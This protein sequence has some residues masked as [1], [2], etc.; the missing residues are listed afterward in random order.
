M[1]I[2]ELVLYNFGAYQGRQ[3]FELT[4]PSSEKPVTLIGGMNGGGKTTFLDA[5]QLLLYGKRANCSNRGNQAYDEFLADSIHRNAPQAEGA[6]IEMTF[7]HH[8]DGA[9]QEFKV[10]RSW[11][12]TEKSVSESVEVAKNGELDEVI[13]ENWDEYV[14]EFIPLG[15]SQLFL[16]DG[17]KIARFAELENST[18]LLRSAIYTLLGLD[19]VDQLS[20]DLVALSRRKQSEMKT[21]EE[22]EKIEEAREE[23]E[24]LED[25]LDRVTQKRGEVQKDLDKRQKQ[26]EDIENKYRREGGELYEK[27]QEL[28]QERKEVVREL[29]AVKDELR[30]LAAGAA[31]MLLVTDLLDDVAEQD[32]NEQE[33]MKAEILSDTLEDRDQELLDEV[34]DEVGL[35]DDKTGAIAELLERDR[36]E[37]TEARQNERYLQLH[38]DARHQL[39]TL[40]KRDLDT[41]EQD[42][43]ETLDRADELSDELLKVD[44]KLAAVPDRD[45]IANL[46]EKRE[47]ALIDIEE[48]ETRLAKYDEKLEEVQ[49]KYE[50]ARSE[51]VR[52]I[53]KEVDRDFE[54]EAAKRIVEHSDKVRDTLDDFRQKVVERHVERIED[55]VLES[56]RTLMRKED[57]IDEVSIDTSHFEVALF[58]EKGREFPPKRLSAGERQLFAVSLLWGLARASGRP[59]PTVIDTPLGRLDS[60]HRMHLVK[61]YF[62]NASHQVI[63]LSTD[64]EIYG[65]YYEELKSDIG[66][67]YMLDHDDEKKITEVREGYFEELSRNVA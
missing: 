45:A 30:D 63:L 5:I 47:E 53:E 1:I 3:V 21:E 39:E 65:E 32:E 62:P 60:S 10:R 51:V 34:K 28:E 27:Q 49:N 36:R 56:F 42:V 18:D 12:P 46:I 20:T 15:I 31:P 11:Y 50:E 24:R 8:S 17:E 26:L 67:E 59:L 6:A 4:P 37:R 61:R 64:E 7:R 54:A 25:E 66:H 48:L 43:A 40:L 14:E 35:G 52:M 41:A 13:T 29:E 33:A 44:R 23:V 2:D 58:D 57:L 22:Q 38:E 9:E 19:I 55:L 16:F